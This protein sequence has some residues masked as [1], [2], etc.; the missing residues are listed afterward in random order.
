MLCVCGLQFR[1]RQ[2]R[3]RVAKE[4]RLRVPLNLRIVAF[5][6]FSNITDGHLAAWECY[7]SHTPGDCVL[8]GAK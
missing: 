8:C 7:E 3:E 2:W 1:E 5:Q 4:V 6:A